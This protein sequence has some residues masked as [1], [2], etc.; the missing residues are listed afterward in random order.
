M[1]S[2]NSSSF[3]CHLPSNTLVEGNKTGE[4]RVRMKNPLRFNSEWSVGLAVISYPYSWPSIGTND[5]QFI[6]I[7]WRRPS[8]FI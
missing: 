1:M 7:N 2:L 3:Y 5:Q 8:F 6:L 4:F